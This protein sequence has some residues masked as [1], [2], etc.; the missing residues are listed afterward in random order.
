MLSLECQW[1]NLHCGHSQRRCCLQGQGSGSARCAWVVSNPRWFFSGECFVC[2]GSY[3]WLLCRQTCQLSKSELPTF[4]WSLPNPPGYKRRLNLALPRVTHEDDES[5][6]ALRPRMTFPRKCKPKN[7]ILP[8]VIW[9]VTFFTPNVAH[10]LHWL[11]EPVTSKTLMPKTRPDSKNTFLSGFPVLILPFLGQHW[12]HISEVTKPQ[13][14]GDSLPP[15][16]QRWSVKTKEEIIK[17]QLVWTSQYI[18][19]VLGAC[20]S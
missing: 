1:S 4:A 16:E 10:F 15:M 9:R 5:V 20:F 7:S 6:I 3:P 8:A 14:G 17:T 18:W 2:L 12:Y 19:E 11:L 13:G